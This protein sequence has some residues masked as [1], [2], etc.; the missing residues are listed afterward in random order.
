MYEVTTR[1]LGLTILWERQGKKKVKRRRRKK[2]IQRKRN[3]IACSGPQGGS[4]RT[5]S[6]MV[7]FPGPSLYQLPVPIPGQVWDVRLA[8]WLAAEVSR[9]CASPPEHPCQFGLRFGNV[10][11][12]ES[13]VGPPQNLLHAEERPRCC[14][15]RGVPDALCC[16][17]L[18]APINKLRTA[19]R[20][21]IPRLTLRSVGLDC[22][23]ES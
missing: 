18:S 2:K 4:D 9:H 7:F 5:Q 20:Y 19:E 11:A 13:A 1:P 8:G 22:F 16:F 12:F 6:R 3:L 14:A 17:G 23:T 21:R 10:C 15:W